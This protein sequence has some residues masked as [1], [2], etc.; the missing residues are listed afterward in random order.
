[1]DAAE[2]KLTLYPLM[3]FPKS[4]T[5]FTFNVLSKLMDVPAYFSPHRP[6]VNGL[7]RE[8]IEPSG[9]PAQMLV[10]HYPATKENLE[11][12]FSY[13]ARPVF[14]VRNIFDVLVSISEFKDWM[15]SEQIYP[16][17]YITERW[18]AISASERIDWAIDCFLGWYIAFYLSWRRTDAFMATY[19]VMTTDPIRHFQQIGAH[20]GLT[21]RPAAIESAMAAV[22]KG[23]SVKFNVGV[24]GRGS[25]LTDEQR[26]RVMATFAHY[27]VSLEPLTR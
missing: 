22:G 16:F 13:R 3:T 26:R 5:Y 11:L 20:W 18:A 6:G 10:G 14:L 8:D 24:S 17:G 4:G 7:R 9:L 21:F 15:G 19:E 2:Q 25:T 12:L 27:G 23:Q 1:M